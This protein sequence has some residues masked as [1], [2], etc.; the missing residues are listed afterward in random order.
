MKKTGT[1]I[2]AS[3]A[4]LFLIAVATF[5]GWRVA[6]N[7]RTQETIGNETPNTETAEQATVY[8]YRTDGIYRVTS[9]NSEPEK[10]VETTFNQE[11]GYGHPD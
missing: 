11:K 4:S 10:I 3:L 6:D 9:E 7:Y 1:I 8:F 2:L 5:A